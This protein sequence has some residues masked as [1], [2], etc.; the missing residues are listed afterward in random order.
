MHSEEVVNKMKRFFKKL[1]QQVQEAV[2]GVGDTLGPLLGRQDVETAG[3]PDRDHVQCGGSCMIRGELD[4]TIV[5]AKN[6]PDT[7][8]IFFMDILDPARS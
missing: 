5:S 4:V 3:Q 2:D 6:L 1:G 8:N 7:D